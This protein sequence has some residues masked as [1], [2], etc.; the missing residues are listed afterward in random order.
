MNL[1]EIAQLIK[2][3]ICAY[4]GLE[5]EQIEGRSRVGDIALARHVA[6]YCINKFT[7]L[8]LKGIGKLF[9]ERDHG[10]VLHSIKRVKDMLSVND[11]HAASIRHF[12][13]EIR[14]LLLRSHEA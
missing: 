2:A 5:V 6:I 8:T 14:E 3:R 1:N 7:T 9:G 10:T 13:G 4:Y 11:E 12:E